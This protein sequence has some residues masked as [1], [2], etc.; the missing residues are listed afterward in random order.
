MNIHE[1]TESQQ[2]KH[3]WLVEQALNW[4]GLP[5]VHLRA[6]VFLEHPFF[7]LFSASSIAKSN[8]IR[9]PFGNGR[10]SPIAALDVARVAATFLSADASQQHAG[11]VYELTG[12]KSQ[13][14]LGIADE[15]S[16]ALNRPIRY[17]DV[18]LEEWKQHDLLSQGLPPHLVNHLATMATL[19]HK[20][21]YDRFSDDFKKVTGKEPMTVQE[22]VASNVSLFQQK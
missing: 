7:A 18:P 5:V 11:K 14:M 2:Q 19:H 15:F 4:S 10:T 21:F 17:V 20:N 16:K 12:P 8:E 13:D 22:W 3:H 1:T 9:L 6:T